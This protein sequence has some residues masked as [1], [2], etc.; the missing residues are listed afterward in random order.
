MRLPGFTADRVFTGS[1]QPVT[2]VRHL[3]ELTA[4]LGGKPQFNGEGPTLVL[5]WAPVVTVQLTNDPFN[6]DMSPDEVW[7]RWF[8]HFWGTPRGLNLELRV[9]PPLPRNMS[10]R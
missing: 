5:H 8:R 9:T 10:Q 3:R 7:W 1:N 4:T 6:A 2:R